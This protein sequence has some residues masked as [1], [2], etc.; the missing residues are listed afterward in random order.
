MSRIVQSINLLVL[1][2][3]AHS[4]NHDDDDEFK[5]INSSFK[6][7]RLKIHEC[8]TKFVK[9]TILGAIL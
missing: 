5:R 3:E 7:K 4:F 1:N 9:N 6:K 8:G 2:E